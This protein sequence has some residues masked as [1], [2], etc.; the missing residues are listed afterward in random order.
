MLKLEQEAILNQLIIFKKFLNLND[1]SNNLKDL[2]E[3]DGI[4]ETSL[5]LIDSFSS[6]KN[7]F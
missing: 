3:L 7:K 4:G 6:N 1:R 5:D 2:L